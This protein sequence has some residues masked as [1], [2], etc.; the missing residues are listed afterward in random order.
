MR[1][2]GVLYD[3]RRVVSLL[4]VRALSHGGS[5]RPLA[6]SEIFRGGGDP[7]LLIRMEVGIL[8]MYE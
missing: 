3:S 2:T 8:Y 7:C 6:A 4:L 1:V 5:P